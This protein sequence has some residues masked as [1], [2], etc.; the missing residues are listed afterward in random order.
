MECRV[1]GS[2]CQSSGPQSER[3]TIQVARERRERERAS[4]RGF[5]DCGLEIGDWGLRSRMQDEGC[6]V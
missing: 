2:G 5:G 1:Y 3:A 4:G 6:R